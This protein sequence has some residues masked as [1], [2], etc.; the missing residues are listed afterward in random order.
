MYRYILDSRA[1]EEYE[2]SVDWYAKRSEQATVK[3]INAVTAA[4]E[5]ICEHPYTY[6][7]FKTNCYEAILKKYPFSI[8]YT[9]EDF[10]ES[11]I[12]LSIFHHKRN[13][14]KKYQ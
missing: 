5:L 1:Q 9:I 7:K 3:F 8:I 11:I 2:T 6:K 13:P 14:K 4:L 10:S 12:I